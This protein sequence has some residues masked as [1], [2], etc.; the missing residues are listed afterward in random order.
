MEYIPRTDQHGRWLAADTS[1]PKGRSVLY[2]GAS[3][4]G[5]TAE[6]DRAEQVA[7]SNGHDVL[8][9]S[10]LGHEP[11]EYQI[12][13]AVTA[14]LDTLKQGQKGLPGGRRRIKKLRRTMQQMVSRRETRRFSVDGGYGR[15]FRL[16]AAR[17]RQ[18][19]LP[20]TTLS[21][22][23]AC[24]S[25]LA[26]AR[27]A[28]SVLM[29]DDL[30]AASQKDLAEVNQLSTDLEQH[31]SR[32]HFIGAGRDEVIGKLI[33]ASGGDSGAQNDISRQYDIRQCQPI[34]DEVL[35]FTLAREMSRAGVFLNPE[36]S[37]QILTEANGNPQRLT[38]LR[39]SAMAYA[40]PVLP[41]DPSSG[42]RV[43]QTAAQAAIGR[44]RKIKEP[45]YRNAWKNSADADRQLLGQIAGRGAR[46]LTVGASVRR[47]GDR[48]DQEWGEIDAAR[49]RLTGA[50]WIR[51]SEAGR[52]RYTDPGMQAWVADYLGDSAPHLSNPDLRQRETGPQSPVVGTTKPAPDSP[53]PGPSTPLAGPSRAGNGRNPRTDRFGSGV[54]QSPGRVGRHRAERY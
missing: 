42:L 36:A 29:I 28:Q 21:D 22:V 34:P 13:R 47:L 11:L 6:L 14:E 7:R 24:L 25:D 9:L 18:V 35:Q 31:P 3:G 20:D 53:V 16:T 43:D 54:G 33:S 45:F 51:E 52:L 44:T 2:T 12:M 38:E 5:K 50:G 26:E 48:T 23:A 30:H 49:Q 17:D 27:G 39:Q 15:L 10:V 37:R 40:T 19:Q 46:G 8:R 4:M 41:N 1:P 32:T